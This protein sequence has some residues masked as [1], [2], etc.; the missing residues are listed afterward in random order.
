M[1]VRYALAC[2][3]GLRSSRRAFSTSWIDSRS[4]SPRSPSTTMQDKVVIPAMRAALQRRSPTRITYVPR[5]SSHADPDRLELTAL[6]ERV[7][8][9]AEG[10]L[11]EFLPRLAGVG[12]DAV[13][14][15]PHR[16]LVPDDALEPGRHPPRHRRVHA[17]RRPRRPAG[18]HALGD[19][20]PPAF[21]SSSSLPISGGLLLRLGGRPGLQPRRAAPGR[22]PPGPSRWP[23]AACAR[24][25]ACGASWP[26]GCRRR[27]G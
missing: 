8:Q 16:V 18:T 21:I 17:G 10:L 23:R 1:S 5:A 6:A 14:A 20:R 3:M 4:A 7:G 22:A 13:N 2:S 27:A 24:R 19:V 25:S 26:P 15:D 11:V 12:R 9:A